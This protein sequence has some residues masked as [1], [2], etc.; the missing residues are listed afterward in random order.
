MSGSA[1][2]AAAVYQAAV[3]CMVLTSFILF[4]SFLVS[5]V[6]VVVSSGFSSHSQVCALLSSVDFL[7]N[8]AAAV[9]D[10]FGVLVDPTAAPA[11]MLFASI[12]C[13][14]VCL[15]VCVLHR[16]RHQKTQTA[17]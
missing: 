6:V 12:H 9:A 16:R 15:F 17:N 5:V 10:W 7:A 1:S 3:F 2:S 4:S 11:L 14:S 8:S 13:L